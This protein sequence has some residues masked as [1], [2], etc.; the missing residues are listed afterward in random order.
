MPFAGYPSFDACVAENQDKQSPEGFCAWLEHEVTGRWPGEMTLGLPEPVAVAFW[1]AF[2]GYMENERNEQKAMEFAVKSASDLGWTRQRNGWTRQADNRL[3]TTSVYGVPIFASG[4]HNGDTYTT[5][6]LKDMIDAFYELKGRLDPPVKIGHTSDEFN[7]ALAEEMGIQPQMIEGETGNGIMAFG[8]VD[9]LRLSGNVLY[10]DLADVP[11]P[12]AEL[13]RSSSYKK[14]SAEVL[15]DFNDAGK[16]YPKVLSGLA[17]L[18]AELPAVRESGLDTAAVYMAAVRPSSVIEF[19][20]DL[21]EVTYEQLEPS[22]ADIDDAIEKAMK[23]RAGVGVIRAMWKD[24]KMKVRNMFESRKHSEILPG[25]QAHTETVE[26]VE[27]MSEVAKKLGLAENASEADILAA[28]KKLQDEAPPESPL[29]AIL[30]KLGLPEDGT[31]ADIL[32]KLDSMMTAAQAGGTVAQ[33]F[34]DRVNKLEM[35]NKDLKRKLRK[36][37]YRDIALTMTAISGTPDELAEE[38]VSLEDAAGKEQAEKVVEKYRALNK[39]MVEAGVFKAKG[40]PAEGDEDDDH[41][42]LKKVRAYMDEH[43]VDEPV[44]FA[45]VRKADQK[46]YRDYMAKRKVVTRALKSE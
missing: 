38:L 23:G 40:T 3:N 35:D 15:F 39:R 21:E 27:N 18:G 1:Q 14:V 44:A 43:K 28:V 33:Q 42:F 30:D 17:L 32:A 46:L 34:S 26:E 37:E 4:E 22:L 2:H 6:D 29:K 25:T 9:E 16:N 7:K 11:D 13:I 45:A 41:E 5:D 19:A 36:S 31:M 8:W 12:I 10:A 20:I 24:V